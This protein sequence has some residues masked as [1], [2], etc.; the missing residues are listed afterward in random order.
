VE[1]TLARVHASGGVTVQARAVAVVTLDRA[2]PDAAVERFVGRPESDIADV[3]RDVLASA[4]RLTLATHPH[5]DV[6][7]LRASLIAALRDDLGRL[8]LVLDTLLS[9]EA[10]PTARP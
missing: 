4:L 3:S 10:H 8:G 9:V 2:H 7:A 5:D 6:D 1:A